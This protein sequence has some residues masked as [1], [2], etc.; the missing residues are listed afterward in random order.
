[1][2]NGKRE[3]LRDQVKL[4]SSREGKK[5]EEER[6]QLRGICVQLG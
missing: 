2:H 4:P 1:M 6:E 3:K 5:K